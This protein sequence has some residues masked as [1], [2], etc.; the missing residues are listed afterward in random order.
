MKRIVLV[1]GWGGKP[2]SNWLPWLKSKMEEKG[3]TVAAP[4]MPNTDHPNLMAWIAKLSEIIGMP[5]ENCY[6]VGHSLGCIT[7]LR[8]LASLN[9]G[10][11]IGG[12]VLVAGFTENPGIKEIANFFER[13]LDYEKAK[14]HCGKFIALN[15]DNDKYV[16]VEL[17]HLLQEK[18]GAELLIQHLGHFQEAEMPVVLDSVER[19]S[20]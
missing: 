17:G 11:K 3:F 15:S 20:R 9:P 13:P 18:L 19:I 16:P 8:Y 2:D 10:E 4:E 6:L 7:I 5:E 1:H 14:V 12:A